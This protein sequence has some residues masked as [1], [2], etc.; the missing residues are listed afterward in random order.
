MKRQLVNRIVMVVSRWVWV[1]SRRCARGTCMHSHC[2]GGVRLWVVGSRRCARGKC[3]E[4]EI[5]R[6][7]CQK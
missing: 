1:G 6:E 3:S 2:N 7:K 5:S 4:V